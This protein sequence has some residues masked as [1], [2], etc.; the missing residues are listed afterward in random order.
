VDVGR[1]AS[2][3]ILEYS[4][5]P[6]WDSMPHHLT[7]SLSLRELR[8]VP[9]ILKREHILSGGSNPTL[10]AT[11]YYNRHPEFDKG[12]CRCCTEALCFFSTCYTFKYEQIEHNGAATT[13]WWEGVKW[14]ESAGISVVPSG[15]PRGSK[16]A[17]VET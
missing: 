3:A 12:L 13:L 1:V 11:K 5:I 7:F 16:I 17:Q 14:S 15:T 9:P 4:Y 10:S 2:T 6:K 8:H